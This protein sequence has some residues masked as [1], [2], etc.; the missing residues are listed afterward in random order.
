MGQT[1]RQWMHLRDVC[2]ELDLEPSTVYDL[3]YKRSDFPPAYKIAG[4]L[5]WKREDIDAWVEA[6][7]D[8]V[9]TS[10]SA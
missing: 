1:R 9:R 4:R 3:R 2:D 10:E 6:Q 8:D 5:R 7:R